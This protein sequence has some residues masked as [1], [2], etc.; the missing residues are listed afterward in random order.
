MKV[1]SLRSDIDVHNLDYLY[2]IGHPLEQTIVQNHYHFDA[3]NEAIDFIM[4]ELNTRFNDLSIELFYLSVVLDP[5]IHLNHLTVMIFASLQKNS[6]MKIL[7]IKT[8]LL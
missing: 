5:K 8:S 2:K 3:F 1:F 7:Q 4:L 6:I